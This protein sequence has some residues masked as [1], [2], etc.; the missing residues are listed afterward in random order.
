MNVLSIQSHVAYGHVGNASAVFPMQRLGVE[1]WPVHTV[2]FSNHTGYGAWRGPIFE[3]DM[4]RDVVRGIG[5]RGVFPGC[6]AVL[7]GYMGSAAIGAAILEAVASVRAANPQ[8]LYCCDPVIGDVAE[9]VY[10]RPGIEAFLRDHAVPAADILT[11]N[12]FELD[13]LTG[14]PSRTLPEAAAAIAALQARGPRVVLVT[15]ALCAD[16]PP[17]RIDL[18]AGAEGRVFRVRTP[19]LAIA[20][21]GA[22]DCIAALF[23]VH[24]A[25]TGSAATALGAAAASVYG[26][27][28]RTAAAGS[29]EILTV[30][31][32]AEYVTPTETFLVE[33]V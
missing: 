3:A 8:A 32:Q 15:S 25:R 27:L 23:L 17:D 12:Q 29:R 33:A 19:R 4:I 10:V 26:L 7:S 31:A 28:K 18:L 16:T 1:V 11:P 24:Y 9:G 30:A 21:N 20:V 5:E 2:Q 13:R 6:D 14:L 22:G